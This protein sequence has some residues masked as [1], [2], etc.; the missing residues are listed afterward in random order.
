M[1]V[2]HRAFVAA[3]H[4]RNARA[5]KVAIAQADGCTAACEGHREIRGDRRLAHAAL[6]ACH[7]DDVLYAIN[8]RGPDAGHGLRGRLDIDLH[9]RPGHAGG[10]QHGLR[11]IA[12]LRG[13]SRLVCREDHLHGHFIPLDNDLLH[14]AKRHDVA[15]KSRILHAPQRVSIPCSSN[16]GTPINSAT[17]GRVTS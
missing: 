12:N 7:G 10:G 13:D 15:R 2:R 4:E 9:N 6:A 16:C 11:L 8:L 1:F 14:E 3:E 17:C 5:V